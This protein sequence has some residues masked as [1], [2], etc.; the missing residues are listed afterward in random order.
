M[1]TE[2][3]QDAAIIITQT[4]VVDGVQKQVVR[5]IPYNNFAAALGVDLFFDEGMQTL[6]MVNPDGE[7]IGNG[8]AV[9]TGISG[10]AMTT[11]TDDTGTQY[12]ILSDQDGS[13]ICRTEFNVSGGGSGTNYVCRLVN[14]MSSTKL[15]FPSGQAHQLL[16]A[17]YEYYGN[18]QTTV[19][20]T[21]EIFT[22]TATTEYEARWQL[23]SEIPKDAEVAAGTFVTTQ[24]WD[25]D[26]LWDI[27]T[28]DAERTLKSSYV[29]FYKAD[30][31]RYR[32]KFAK[33]LG[34][35][36]DS[37]TFFDMLTGYGFVEQGSTPGGLTVWRQ[38]R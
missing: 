37:M 35:T 28:N 30:E 2:L 27:K 3:A 5:R 23:L 18:E 4:E 15:S 10:L 21:C 31:Q 1:S 19:N 13:E 34:I 33:D 17:F 22:K 9:Q 6:Y 25:R 16:Y 11:E 36:D 24:V 8:T 26:L 12:L 7:T 38:N 29:A 14:R 20:A 32:E